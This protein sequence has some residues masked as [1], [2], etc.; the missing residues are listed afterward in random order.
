MPWY[1]IVWSSIGRKIIT[2][3]AGLGLYLYLVI[4]LAGN[5]TLFTRNPDIFNRY[6]NFLE[7]LGWLLIIVE[8][9]LLVVF[10][11][12]IV[13]GGFVWYAK[14]R[15]RGGFYY[16]VA[17]AGPP[18]HKTLSSKSMILTGLVLGIFITLHVITFK[19]GPGVKEGYITM[20]KGVE[21]RDLYRLVIEVFSKMGYVVFYVACMIFLFYHLR[22]AFWSGFQSLGLNNKYLVPFFYGLGF[23]LAVLLAL[24][25]VILPVF[26]Y[27]TGGSS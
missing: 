5:A 2:A 9:A 7:S 21:M 23:I 18:S 19:Y 20:I 11:F 16:K 12:H 27:F 4:H 6:A 1:E 15:A 13:V 17:D 3:V 25:F 14:L 24:G 10:I 8:I 22:H 26:I